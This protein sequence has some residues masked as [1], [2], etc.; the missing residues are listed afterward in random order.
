MKKKIAVEIHKSGSLSQEI[1][2][3]IQNMNEGNV[4]F[5]P[6]DLTGFIRMKSAMYPIVYAQLSTN[7]NVG[8]KRLDISED[9]GETFTLSLTWKEVHELELAPQAPTL[10]LQNIDDIPSELFTQ[11]S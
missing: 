1:I 5:S 8:E 7:Y 11:K 10:L 9:G 6:D 3:A 2:S 4:S